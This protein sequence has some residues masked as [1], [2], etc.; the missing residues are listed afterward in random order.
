MESSGG[1][2]LPLPTELWDRIPPDVQAA[3]QVVIE[4]YEQRFVRWQPL[5]KGREDVFNVALQRVP[6]EGR[7]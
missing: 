7:P 2:E 4:G 1:R 6:L 3:L 5:P